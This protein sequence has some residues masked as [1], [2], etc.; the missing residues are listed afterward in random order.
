MTV[1]ELIDILHSHDS[2]VN[3]KINI[4]KYEQFQIDAIEFDSASS[5]LYLVANQ[6]AE[7]Y[8][9]TYSSN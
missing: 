6:P 3:V 5:A 7:P 9:E 1:S 4:Q 2:N 8:N